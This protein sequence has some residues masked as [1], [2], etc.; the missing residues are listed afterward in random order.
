VEACLEEDGILVE[1]YLEEDGSLVEAYREEGGYM[2]LE[3]LGIQ[4]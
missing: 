1:A 4:V 3:H 2:R